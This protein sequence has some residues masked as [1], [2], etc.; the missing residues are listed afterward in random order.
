MR[1]PAGELKSKWYAKNRERVLSRAKKHYKRLEPD[2]YAK[3]VEAIERGAGAAKKR[4]QENRAFFLTKLGGRCVD[5]GYDA[6]PSVIQFDHVDPRTK[7]RE[8]AALMTLKNRDIIWE[9]V[10][11]CVL[12]CA[13]CHIVKSLT[14]GDL[15]RSRKR[16]SQTAVR[17]GEGVGGGTSDSGAS[18]RTL[19]PFLGIP[20]SRAGGVSRYPR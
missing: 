1:K 7:S 19:G 14:Q 2:Q 3:Y 6:H 10:Q 13:N 17:A 20:W 8:V 9:E 16:P 12:R 18:W 5:C 15:G 4:R 11:K